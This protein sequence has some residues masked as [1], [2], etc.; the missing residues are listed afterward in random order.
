MKKWFVLFFCSLLLSSLHAQTEASFMKHIKNLCAKE[1]H[2]RGA[3]FNGDKLAAKYIASRLKSCGLSKNNGTFFQPFKYDVNTFPGAYSLSI[4][5]KQLRPGIDFMVNAASK[6]GK[7]H[8]KA[9]RLTAEQWSDPKF[10]EKFLH[11]PLDHKAIFYDASLNNTSTKD[12]FKLKLAKLKAACWIEVIETDPIASEFHRQIQPTT[13]SMKSN[14]VNA[15]GELK[16]VDI[17]I[18]AKEIV[19][20][21]SQNVYGFIRG[22]SFPN[23]Y[24]IVS[25]HYDHIGHLGKDIYLQ[26]ANDNAT[27]VAM[28]LSLAEHFSKPENQPEK[29]ILFLFFAAEEIGLEG[30]KH[31]VKHP[32]VPLDQ[33]NFVLNLDLVGSGSEGITVVNGI[34][35]PREYDLLN[36][37]NKAGSFSPEIK[38]RS[39]KANSDHFPFTTKSVPAFFV[40]AR[41][42]VG[43]YHNLGDTSDK[44]EK[45]QFKNLFE[46]FKGFI[47]KI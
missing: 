1:L 39:N 16:N 26:G 10:R 11:K 43:G 18:D 5:G 44:L 12:Y 23:D 3:E 25:A 38:K 36:E 9:V 6:S 30:S 4:N 24:V 15:I 13:F 32:I 7:G 17:D 42:S 22:K 31:Y 19:D 34:E 45:G 29:S 14:V 37:V 40:Y 33:T 46:L 27:G 20:Y 35:Q 41:G 21:A 28:L 8:Y 47:L 2:G